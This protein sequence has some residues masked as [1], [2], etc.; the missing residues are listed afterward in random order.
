MKR[1]GG[2]RATARPLRRRPQAKGKVITV[3]RH[4]DTERPA[5]GGASAGDFLAKG[6]LF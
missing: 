4:P 5:A 1:V 6:D 2:L 3:T